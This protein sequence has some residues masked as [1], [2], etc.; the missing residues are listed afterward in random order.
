MESDVN[1]LEAPK[2]NYLV[3]EE[4]GVH[5]LSRDTF[6]HFVMPKDLV[7]VEFYAPWC[8]HCKRMK[9]DYQ[10]AATE[11]K[12]KAVMAAM[13]VNKPENTPI[14][15]KYNIT[16]FPTLL[17]FEGGELQYPYPGGNNKEVGSASQ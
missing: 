14:S 5:V 6:A 15:R 8:G 17:Y 4:E 12:G 16:G 10:A 13:D 2:G 9:P 11:M 7:L 1:P 3:M